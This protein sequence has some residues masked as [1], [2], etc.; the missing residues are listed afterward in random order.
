MP[1]WARIA[2]L[3]LRIPVRALGRLRG[4]MRLRVESPRVGVLRCRILME[5][6]TCKHDGKV[7]S[8]REAAGRWLTIT[9]VS[10]VLKFVDIPLKP[11]P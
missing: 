2:C 3:L 7:E 4:R 11:G 10:V 9:K 5:P 1:D 6:M 8:E